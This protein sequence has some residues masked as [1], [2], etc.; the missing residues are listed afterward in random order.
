MKV[1]YFNREE[2]VHVDYSRL[3]NSTGS[4]VTG[5]YVISEDIALCTEAQGG[6]PGFGPVLN[7]NEDLLSELRV[8]KDGH[9]PD[10]NGVR[11]TRKKKFDL[12]ENKTKKLNELIE[13]VKEFGELAPK[14][15]SLY[16]DIN[17][18]YR[19]L[20]KEINK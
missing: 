19:E 1:L 17:L 3:S 12:D 7:D 18:G 16:K 14:Y 15:N 9:T 20:V 13:K 8:L 6:S 10:K 2:N 5:I 4:F 11:Y